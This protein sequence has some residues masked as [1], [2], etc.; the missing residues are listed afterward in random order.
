MSYKIA[1]TLWFLVA[2]QECLHSN[3]NEKLKKDIIN[4]QSS[5]NTV[6]YYL[7]YFLVL[8]LLKMRSIFLLN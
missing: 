7:E 8:F 6:L 4:F 2:I 5:L 1:I 3:I